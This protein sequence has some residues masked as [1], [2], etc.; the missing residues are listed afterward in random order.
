M[1]TMIDYNGCTRHDMGSVG[2][3][4]ILLR[5][6]AE[7]FEE[8]VSD[9]ET[10]PFMIWF[11][12]SPQHFRTIDGSYTKATAKMKGAILTSAAASSSSSA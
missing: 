2:L 12:T 1:S 5:A 10:R 4:S 7:K 8:F 3:T 9:L 6:V 11:D